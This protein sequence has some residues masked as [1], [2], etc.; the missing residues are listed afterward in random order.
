MTRKL[1]LPLFVNMNIIFVVHYYTSDWLVV[2][3]KFNTAFARRQ[4]LYKPE[5]IFKQTRACQ[6][7]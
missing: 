3:L 4:K 7:F 5:S 1:L 6:L 2:I